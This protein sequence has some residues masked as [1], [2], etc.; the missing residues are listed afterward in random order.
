VRGAPDLSHI[1]HVDG[2]EPGDRQRFEFRWRPPPRSDVPLDVQL[3]AGA[4]GDAGL[5]LRLEPAEV[6][7]APVEG[8]AALEVLAFDAEPEGDSDLT[9][10][11]RAG[12]TATLE[13]FTRHVCLGAG[14]PEP[15]PNGFLSWGPYVPGRRGARVALRY[16][17]L[18]DR[19]S[20]KVWLDIAAAEGS[21][22]VAR[23]RSIELDV[24]GFRT[25]LLR[26]RLDAHAADLEGRLNAHGGERVE[27][28]AIVVR[29]AV[30][31]LEAAP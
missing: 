24:P 4:D 2:L 11:W 23:S 29:A 12:A 27:P 13:Q 31:R 16:D 18:L 28:G 22:V 6:Q 7:P 9:G 30:L 10:A 21:V 14:R 3:F 19:S 17:L 1:A 20:P 25:L 26:A 5:E 8:G 15:C